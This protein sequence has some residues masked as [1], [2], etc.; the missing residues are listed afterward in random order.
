MAR[1]WGCIGIPVIYQEGVFANIR[2]SFSA[3]IWTKRNGNDSLK[4]FMR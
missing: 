4:V 2:A 1:S 3:G